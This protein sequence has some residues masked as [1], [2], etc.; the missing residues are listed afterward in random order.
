MKKVESSMYYSPFLICDPLYV[1][2][3]FSA[4]PLCSCPTLPQGRPFLAHGFLPEN[5]P[6]LVMS[7]SRLYN[8]LALLENEL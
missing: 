2:D 1:I 8:R 5:L 4:L 7:L 3:F 6:L